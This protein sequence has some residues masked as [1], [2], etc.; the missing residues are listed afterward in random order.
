MALAAVALSR[1]SA[2]E[3]ERGLHHDAVARVGFAI[4]V[5]GGFANVVDR[6]AR[7]GVVDF[8]HIKGWPIFN[9]ADIAIVVGMLLIALRAARQR[10][11]G[12]FQT[13]T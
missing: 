13:R 2:S 7:G 3:S 11:D 10:D 4:A 12:S 5:G 9:V 8:I 1:R 6:A